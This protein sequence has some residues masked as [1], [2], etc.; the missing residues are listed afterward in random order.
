MDVLLQL[1]SCLNYLH[2]SCN[3]IHRDIKPQNIL[4]DEKRV[5]LADFGIAK[6]ESPNRP[7]E[8]IM[9]GTPDYLSPEMRKRQVGQPYSYKVDIFSLGCTIFELIT[10]EAPN[11]IVVDP[12]DVKKEK[13]FH[14]IVL[15]CVCKVFPEQGKSLGIILKGMLNLDDEL[16]SSS[17][18]VL[19]QLHKFFSLNPRTRSSSFLKS[20]LT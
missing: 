11:K 19:E 2:H 9:V 5:V 14:E 17:K 20:S 3:I 10:L 4:L 18:T 8:T 16:R 13:K 6:K 12:Y 15:N 1:S 7:N